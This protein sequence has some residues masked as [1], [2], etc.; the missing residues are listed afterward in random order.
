MGASRAI[1]E[2]AW[3]RSKGRGRRALARMARR[4]L[5]DATVSLA[6]VE[7]GVRLR[8]HLRR[9]VM[10][11][12]GGLARYEPQC[13]R[14]LRAAV[15]PG[16]VV[17]DVGANIGFY[18]MLLSRWVGPAGLVLAV[19][20]DPENVALL[21]RN[22]AENR[23]DNVQVCPHAVGARPGPG[24][25]SRDRA[26]GATG[27]VGRSATAGELAVGTGRVQ[28]VSTRVET[29]DELAD[30]RGVVPALV[31]LD[32]EG[33]EAQALEGAGRT[34]AEHRPVIVSEVSGEGARRVL[35][36]LRGAGYRAWDLET[37]R[38]VDRGS[39]P[40]MVV[41]VPGEAV[42]SAR[43]RG[44]LEALGAAVQV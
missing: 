37:S 38:P 16:D 39:T 43:G 36:I 8:V 30:G 40:F 22:L 12:S 11:W 1:L 5:P 27:H 28:V 19:E 21:R 44:I 6:H 3:Q 23:G 18:T 7:E 4:V 29:L 20:P 15:A 25:F 17:L 31:K 13:V 35:E 24:L 9:N 2:R 34:L 26:T 14:V 33:S 10:F 41:A 32:I 42:A